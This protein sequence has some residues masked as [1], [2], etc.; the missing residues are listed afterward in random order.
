MQKVREAIFGSRQ[1]FVNDARGLVSARYTFLYVFSFQKPAARRRYMYMY[2]RNNNKKQ[3]RHFFNGCQAATG[4]LP[5]AVG[6][7]AKFNIS[8]KG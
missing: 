6:V 2:N 5:T 8:K 7:R 3:F 4:N 1:L